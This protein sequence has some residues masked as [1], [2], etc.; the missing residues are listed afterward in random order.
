MQ[1]GA[2]DS[3]RPPTRPTGVLTVALPTRA[4]DAREPCANETG[5]SLE[6]TIMPHSDSP[7][8]V[9]EADAL[10]AAHAAHFDALMSSLATRVTLEVIVHAIIRVNNQLAAG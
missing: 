7:S 8:F 1:T 2:R 10:H 4:L 6:R 3:A 5:L 9:S